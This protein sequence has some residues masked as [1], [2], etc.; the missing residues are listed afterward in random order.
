MYTVYTYKCMVLANPKYKQAEQCMKVKCTA[1]V[2]TLAG[3]SDSLGNHQAWAR[4]Y[5]QSNLHSSTITG[6]LRTYVRLNLYPGT[7]RELT[8]SCLLLIFL[9][10]LPLGDV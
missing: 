1:F 4:E 6:L 5:W 7:L 8:R 10:L 9:L 2:A 3:P